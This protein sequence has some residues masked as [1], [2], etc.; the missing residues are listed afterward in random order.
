MHLEL[1]SGFDKLVLLGYVLQKLIFPQLEVPAD[2]IYVPFFPRI[3]YSKQSIYRLPFLRD[4]VGFVI[5][6]KDYV[7]GSNYRLPVK[8]L[9]VV[10]VCLIKLR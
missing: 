7:R 6:F 2:T 9:L 3:L 10:I 1:P 5:E 8:L 4:I